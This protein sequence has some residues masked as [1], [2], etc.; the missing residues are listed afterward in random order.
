MSQIISF[1]QQYIFQIAG[2]VTLILVVIAAISMLMKK[3]KVSTLDLD[4]SP[5]AQQLRKQ[6]G[7]RVSH[8]TMDIDRTA[9]T[10]ADMPAYATSLPD[11]EQ[12]ERLGSDSGHMASSAFMPLDQVTSNDERACP[13]CGAMIPATS[14]FCGKCG[15]NL[16]NGWK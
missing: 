3:K 15:H 4:N 12:V 2:V 5:R 8:N 11:A 10:L 7:Q 16:S 6:R 1:L 14:K 9:I 13:G